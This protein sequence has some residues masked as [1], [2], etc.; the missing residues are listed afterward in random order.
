VGVQRVVSRPLE[1]LINN[2]SGSE[3]VLRCAAEHGVDKLILFSSS[4]VYGK[5]ADRPLCEEDD[6]VLGASTVSRW[7]YAASKAVDEFLALAYYE[8][9]DLPVVIVRCF[10]TCGPRQV[11][12]YGMVIPRLVQQ[13]LAGE[14]LTVFGDGEQSRCFSYVGDVVRGVL[15]LAES[16]D[17]VG[18]VFNI[19]TD[20]EVTILELAERIRTVTNSTSDVSLVPYA[21]VYAQ[22]FEDIRRRVPDLTKIE[23]VVGYRPEIGLDALLARIVEHER[24]H[25]ASELVDSDPSP[26]SPDLQ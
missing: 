15:M 11:G 13:A 21:D 16:D 6:S 19:G 23:S 4:E 24:K 12:H 2:I 17:A 3:I 18:Q 1:S 20:S 14:T 10:N 22:S 7:G 26:I 5:A 9:K 8:E 25:A